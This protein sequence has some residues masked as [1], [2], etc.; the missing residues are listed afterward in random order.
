MAEL[1]NK[2]SQTINAECINILA[3]NNQCE[4]FCSDNV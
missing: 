3:D 4:E 1:T 2:G